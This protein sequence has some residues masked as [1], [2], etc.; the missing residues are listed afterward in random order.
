MAGVR[1]RIGQNGRVV[2]PADY[3]RALG[4]K[5]GDEVVLLL[6]D[7]EVRMLT[8]QAAIKEAQA[9]VRRFVPPKRRLADELIKERRAEAAHE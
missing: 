6:R 4:V 2:I 3:R 9:I 5:S 1:T 8:R 7:G